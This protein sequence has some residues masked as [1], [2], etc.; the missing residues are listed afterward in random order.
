[1][2]DN[3]GMPQLWLLQLYIGSNVSLHQ[4]HPDGYAQPTI[5]EEAAES[6]YQV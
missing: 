3:K 2:L 4:L 5:Q 6:I 1:M